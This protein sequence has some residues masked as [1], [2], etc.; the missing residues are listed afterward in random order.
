VQCGAQDGAGP[1]DELTGE[2]GIGVGEPDRM[3]RY[4]D[5]SVVLAPVARRTGRAAQ[6]KAAEWAFTQ[7][8]SGHSSSKIWAMGWGWLEFDVGP[9]RRRQLMPTQSSHVL[10]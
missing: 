8:S 4:A 6:L 9:D 1:V 7:K 2:A 3:K 5:S 10:G